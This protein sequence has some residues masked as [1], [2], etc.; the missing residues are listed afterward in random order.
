MKNLLFD[1][2]DVFLARAM[3]AQ[4]ARF[5]LAHLPRDFVHHRVDRGVKIVRFFAS[6]DRDVVR[7]D[8]HDLGPVPVFFHSEN[9]VGF[10]DFRIIEVQPFDLARGVIVDRVGDRKMAAGDFDIRIGVG[11]LHAAPLV[12]I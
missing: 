2:P 10:D 1:V 4:E 8:E 9:D 3:A 12:Y 11:G 7:A 5:V 6:F